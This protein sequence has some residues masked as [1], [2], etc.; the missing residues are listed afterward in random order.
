MDEWTDVLLQPALQGLHGVYVVIVIIK[1][2]I[3]E[4]LEKI[5]RRYEACLS[6][7]VCLRKKRLSLS[8][9]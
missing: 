2:Y 6:V 3:E 8:G 9:R 7:F 4:P 1:F 5:A